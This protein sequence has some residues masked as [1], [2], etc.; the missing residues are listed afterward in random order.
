MKNSFKYLT[1]LLA[2]AITMASCQK[3]ETA[4]LQAPEVNAST[5]SIVIT[6]FNDEQVVN[7]EWTS[8]S[9]ELAAQYFFQITTS[10]DTEFSSGVSIDMATALS[11][12]YTA[13]EL[14]ELMKE[15]AI[16]EAK[17]FTLMARVRVTSKDA[18]PVV[19][20]NVT[21][22]VAI[23]LPAY[24]PA[25]LFI[26]GN[27]TDFSWNRNKLEEQAL[28][29][30]ENGIFTW[31][32]NLYKTDTD[33]F[34]FVEPESGEFIPAYSRD[35][36]A[37]E[38]WTLRLNTTYDDPDEKFQVAEDGVYNLTLDV[39]N[40]TISA[41]RVGDIYVDPDEVIIDNL[42]AIGDAVA[43]GWSQD[44]AIAMEKIGKNLFRY[45][46]FLSGNKEFKFL[47]QNDGNW[48]PAFVRDTAAEDYWSLVYTA[49]GA[50]D[51]KFVV[52]ADGYYVIT[53]NA[54][55][56]A[57]SISVVEYTTE[58]LYLIGDAFSWGWSQDNAEAMTAT[59]NVG[60]YTWTGEMLGDKDFKILCQNNGSWEPGYN[61]D[62]TAEDDWTLAYRPDGNAPDEKFKVSANGTYTLTVNVL[63][64]TVKAELK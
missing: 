36:Q 28:Q 61:R 34:K 18:E 35:A 10:T 21:V 52:E 27:A 29:K 33:G 53:I 47:C 5:S 63:E 4:K 49:N 43:W 59:E 50:I 12:S 48:A 51:E 32:G 38:Y 44:G 25:T 39:I 15:L 19:S 45:V 20:N 58:T 62:A 6:E 23:D 54:D 41:E 17:E 30:G 55:T 37:T 26:M 60:E 46:S 31:T 2:T 3:N 56:K 8:A 14:S 16:A 22:K 64:R 40:L 7:F 9:N 57:P 11:K 1:I 13:N 24:I 42:Y